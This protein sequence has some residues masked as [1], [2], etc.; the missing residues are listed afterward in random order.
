MT[1]RKDSPLMSSKVTAILYFIGWKHEH[2]IIIMLFAS[3]V[4]ECLNKAFFLTFDRKY[5]RE[6]RRLLWKAAI[7]KKAFQYLFESVFATKKK[8]PYCKIAGFTSSVSLFLYPNLI[9]L[10]ADW[11]QENWESKQKIGKIQR[12]NSKVRYSRNFLVIFPHQI[13]CT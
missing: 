11:Q 7:F 12:T 4:N 5:Y 9:T 1:Y 6:G 8:R 13:L 2:P 10:K 3:V